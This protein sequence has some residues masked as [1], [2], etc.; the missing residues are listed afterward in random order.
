MRSALHFAALGA[1]LFGAQYWW[2]SSAPAAAHPAIVIAPVADPALVDAQIDDEVLFREALARGFDHDRVVGAR[3]VRLGRFLGLAANGDDAHVER[4]A[5]ALG[6]HRSDA[7]IRRH[8]IELMRVAAGKLRPNDH[9]TEAALTAYYTDHPQEFAQPEQIRFTQIYF[10][11]ER[12]GETVAGQAAEVLAQLQQRNVPPEAAAT[13]GDPF[14]R[15]ADLTLS[16]AQVDDVFGP[17]FAATLATMPE[18]SWAGPLQSTYGEH[19]I[20]VRERIAGGAAPY[21]AVRSRVLHELLRERSDAKLRDAL[22]SLR[23]QYDVRIDGAA[24][25]PDRAPPDAPACS[26]DS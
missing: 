8:L 15:T 16:A 18:R 22:A 11:A 5:R 13:F 7:V 17:G 19:L 12:R 2:S 10:S 1:V 21:R 9:P 24:T 6:L 25:L 23:A 26:E 3:L 20:W 4:E 14:V